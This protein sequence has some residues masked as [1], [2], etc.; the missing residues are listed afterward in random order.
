M[1]EITWR[2]RIKD[3]YIFIKWQEKAVLQAEFLNGDKE[4]K[5]SYK[6]I[7][8]EWWLILQR[9]WKMLQI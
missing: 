7:V 8:E 2:E 6:S 4:V 5:K 9:R 1:D 3:K